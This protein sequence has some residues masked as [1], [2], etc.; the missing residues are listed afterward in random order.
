M[1]AILRTIVGTAIELTDEQKKAIT[2]HKGHL[3]I[4]A[5]AGSG[6]TEIIARR[7][8]NLICKERIPPKSIVAFTFTNKAA[9][10]L[11]ARIR[12]K[13]DELVKGNP[14][15]ELADFGDLFVGT[16]DAFCFY[17]L[18]EL[19][20]T[21]RSYSILQEASRI[22]F[23]SR[24]YYSLGL[25]G[26]ESGFKKR[27]AVTSAFASDV[28]LIRRENIAP[29]K[30]NDKNLAACYTKYIAHLHKDRFLDFQGVISTLLE[31]LR[32]PA[33]LESLNARIKHLT[34]DEYQD[35]NRDQEQLIELLSIGCDSVCVVGD[36]DQCI[37]N[38]RGSEVKNI[39]EFK[40]KY[41]KKYDVSTVP[42][43]INYRSTEA[44]IHTAR[45]FVEKNKL[46]TK[47]K[48]QHY[49]KSLN[50]FSQGDLY[51][52]HFPTEE[53]EFSFI[54]DKIK[55][56]VGADFTDTKGNKYALA[57]KDIAILV[58]KNKDAA[59]LITFLNER[60][61]VTVSNE[62]A[63]VI[64]TP[65]VMLALKCICYAVGCEFFRY[66]KFEHKLIDKHAVTLDEVTADYEQVYPKKTYHGADNE[67]LRR[68]LELLKTRLA[69]IAKKGK[70]DYL[71]DT[72]TFQNI[73]HLI[74]NAFGADRFDFNDDTHERKM[75]NLSV[76]SQ[77]ISDFETVYRRLR[78]S[79]LGGLLHFIAT[80]GESNYREAVGGDMSFIEGV[81]VLTV[82]KAK[83]L[84]FPVVF[85]PCQVKSGGHYFDNSFI[86]KSEYDSAKYDSDDEDERRTWYVGMTRAERY[87]FITGSSLKID[88]KR[89]SSPHA[90]IDEI[91]KK[92]FSS[93][94]EPIIKHS[95][96]NARSGDFK[97]LYPTSFSEISSFDRC[98]YEFKF[99]HIFGLNAGVPVTFGYGTNIH[100]ILNLIYTRY[101]TDAPTPD[102]VDKLVDSH[103]YL[104]Y[105]TEKITENMKRAAKKVIKRYVDLFSNDFKN[106]LETEKRF[107]FVLGNAS[108]SGQIDLI[109][110]L[111]EANE[112]VGVEIIDFKTDKE[113]VDDKSPYRL[114]YQTQLRLYTI[115]CMEA[116]GLN[117]KKA[118]IH[119]LDKGTK[120]DITEEIDISI[121]LLDKTKIKLKN[122]IQSIQEEKFPANPVDAVCKRC[123]Y[124]YVCSKKKVTV[125]LP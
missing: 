95:K 48:M 18:K 98:P 79:E 75:F 85:M 20:P 40:S 78:V 87:L 101:K 107:E 44:I 32:D 36:D 58:R 67:E 38:W 3:Q 21:F 46:R 115:A 71:P 69:K 43:E 81:R 113:E 4:L 19:F 52:R 37:F 86:Q 76:L 65:E 29:E 23:I 59:R 63:S 100:N 112:V 83:G 14:P 55:K 41:S 56:F 104:K 122:S 117:P 109:K 7:I 121:P 124:R 99:R 106:V 22:A 11:K 12:A 10:E 62:G 96:L 68:I 34:V 60:G 51:H 84:Q 88:A 123:D 28:D 89:K 1:M 77:A 54:I 103:F 27:Y 50:V 97:D 16:I 108:I 66:N 64:E 53:V 74:L 70:K 93:T 72:F 110:K 119:H 15:V 125:R 35:V 92:Y 73:Y 33:S 118:T 57:L 31:K 2:H 26:L 91:D 82:H 30:L 94:S 13:V 24:Y 90:F 45:R 80:Y 6:K 5:C 49:I 25:K 42:L 39:L 9:D 120:K 116:L 61:V 8:A 102:E 114:D 105:A 17:I 111:N 47:K